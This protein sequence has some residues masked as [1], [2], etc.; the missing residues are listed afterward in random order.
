MA[1]TSSLDRFLGSSE[2]GNKKEFKKTSSKD[3]Q[4]CIVLIDLDCF[5]VSVER[6]HDP[7]LNEKP[8]GVA[9]YTDSETLIAISYEAKSL[10]V[11][12]GMFG[13]Q[14][15]KICPSIRIIKVDMKNGK[16]DLTKYRE[17]SKQVLDIASRF[18]SKIE[19]ASVDEFYLDVTDESNKIS[20]EENLTIKAS[21]WGSDTFVCDKFDSVIPISESIS[22]LV[23]ADDIH[24]YAASL[25]VNRIRKSIKTELTLDCSA[26]IAG[27]KFLAK[28]IAGIRK[29]AT[30]I[31]LPRKNIL[32]LCETMPLKKA[33]SLGGKLGDMLI[34]KLNVEYLFDIYRNVEEIKLL[35]IFGEK[36]AKRLLELARGID[37]TAVEVRVQAKSLGCS[38]NFFGKQKLF[39]RNQISYWLRSLCSELIERLEAD[40]R[41]PGTITV[42]ASGFG[43]RTNSAFKASSRK[44]DLEKLMEIVENLFD[45]LIDG[46]TLKKFGVSSLSLNISNFPEE[47]IVQRRSVWSCVSC[48]FENDSRWLRCEACQYDKAGLPLTSINLT[49]PKKLKLGSELEKTWT[50]SLCSYAENDVRFLR[51]EVCLSLKN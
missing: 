20:T 23:E 22:T 28:S 50:C 27:N 34:E 13:F 41:E 6:M 11:K 17:A 49:Q 33:K 21:T 1:S 9:Q 42:A 5:F 12:R 10:G 40:G 26:G 46:D 16:A 51:C 39:S 8:V 36:E 2:N 47:E 29:P 37:L 18:C 45:K 44:L 48:T 35:E 15:K 32:S 24:L 31:V 38:K 25:I 43:S 19:R 3:F 7:S 4:R 14:A 30:Q